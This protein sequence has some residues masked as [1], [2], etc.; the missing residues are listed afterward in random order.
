MRL[1]L[2]NAF[3]FNSHSGLDMHEMGEYA[4]KQMKIIKILLSLL[5]SLIK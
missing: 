4:C 2:L 3:F 1:Q 5:F